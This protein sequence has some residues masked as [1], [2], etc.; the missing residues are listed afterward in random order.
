MSKRAFAG[1]VVMAM[2]MLIGCGGGFFI[3]SST[4]STATS[5]TGDYVYAVN[6]T[7]NTINEYS[8][9]SAAL[10]LLS[11]SPLTATSGLAA[12][13]V[14]VSRA[15]TFV[16]IGGLGTI[17]SYTIGSAGALTLLT[18]QAASAAS[19]D[20]TALETSPDG[21]WLFA[22][23]A[24]NADVY[25]FKINTSTGALTLSSTPTYVPSG[26]GSFTPRSIRISPAAN[27]VALALGPDG[28]VLMSFNTTTGALTYVS[29]LNISSSAATYSD[30]AVQFDST[31][32][33]LYIAR[34]AATTGAS[35]IAAYTVN[36]NGSL[37][38]GATLVAGNIPYALLLES[39]GSY[40]Y[41]ANRSDSTVS[42]YTPASGVL[43][44]IAGSAYASGTSP[45]AMVE[46]KSHTYVV[47]AGSAGGTDVTLFKLDALTNGKLDAVATA[48]TGASGL[49][50]VAG[51]HGTGTI[52]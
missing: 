26:S 23:D 50:A 8:V 18:A 19:T 43:T 7:T 33:Y 52:Q 49:T 15:N 42:G 41:A 37:T 40:L 48:T 3:D 17:S 29:N 36:S 12:A 5:S 13:S 51:T 16:Y 30:N 22:L 25:V 1:A 47:A 39:S 28:D 45:V 44:A 38:T 10:T 46:D 24:L 34:G 9:G 4:T 2:S 20:F 32:S 35:L 14:A 27:F 6:P 31:G 21:Q 11:G